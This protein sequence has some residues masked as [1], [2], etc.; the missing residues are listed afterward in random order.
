MLVSNL[1]SLSFLLPLW[2][3]YKFQLEVAAAAPEL[4]GAQ[5][6]FCGSV[7]ISSA[8]ETLT[9]Q[10]R[11]GAAGSATAGEEQAVA[12]PGRG[13]ADLCLKIDPPRDGG[14][15]VSLE[16]KDT[17]KRGMLKKLASC[18]ARP[19]PACFS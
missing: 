16:K 19:G 10:A 9:F 4:E 15:L 7:E 5:F 1:V 11:P 14:S 17:A 12:A 13:I 3:S 2:G 6:R 8:D 18:G